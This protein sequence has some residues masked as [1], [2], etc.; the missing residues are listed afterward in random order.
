VALALSLRIAEARIADRYRPERERV[1][2]HF[3]FLEAHGYTVSDAERKELERAE[4]RRAEYEAD[5]AELAEEQGEGPDR[6]TDVL[7][8]A[9]SSG[10]E[11]VTE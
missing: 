2:R 3:A 10:E 1:S 11:E 4:R 9:A 6:S 5:Q 7:A 8:Q